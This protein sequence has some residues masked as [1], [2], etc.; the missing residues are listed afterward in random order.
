MSGMRVPKIGWILDEGGTDRGVKRLRHVWLQLWY[1]AS[2]CL[3]P[4][5]LTN[6]QSSTEREPLS[7]AA[8]HI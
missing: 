3:V 5:A 8:T 4:A 6:Q 1:R 2:M 7:A